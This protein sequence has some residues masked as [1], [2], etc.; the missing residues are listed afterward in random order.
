MQ[1]CFCPYLAAVLLLPALISADVP[2]L[3]P[4]DSVAD[5][6]RMME[7]ARLSQLPYVDEAHRYISLVRENELLE[8]PQP[9]VLLGTAAPRFYKPA[10]SAGA[11]PYDALRVV[12]AEA[13]EVLPVIGAEEE[14]IGTLTR[15]GLLDYM[16]V[17]AGL[18]NPGGTIILEV[19]PRN[20]SLREIARIAEG[21]DITILS[22]QVYQNAETE[23]LDVT[24]KCNR[25]S[26]GGLSQAFAR[27]G[28]EVKAVWGALEDEDGLLGR[29][30]NLMTYLNI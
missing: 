16:V 29:Y 22:S 4:A 30:D 7:D 3:R 19:S 24:L 20:Y 6:L 18:Q 5:A 9:E 1:K 27:F 11:H 14:F 23:M 2:V 26:L 12:H 25:T 17:N 21:E 15:S 10:I 28:Y 13:L 8:I